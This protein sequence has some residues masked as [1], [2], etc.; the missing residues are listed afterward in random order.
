MAEV[1]TTYF[2]A[3]KTLENSYRWIFPALI[4]KLWT[5]ISQNSHTGQPISIS[6]F[7]GNTCFSISSFFFSPNPC[8]PAVLWAQASLP[9]VYFDE[10]IQLQTSFPLSLYALLLFPFMPRLLRVT[11][12]M[13]HSVICLYLCFP[14]M[15]GEISTWTYRQAPKPAWLHGTLKT[16]RQSD[17]SARITRE[18][19]LAFG[20]STEGALRCAAVTNLALYTAMPLLRSTW[21]SV[22]HPDFAFGLHEVV[23]TQ[24]AASRR[25]LLSSH[26]KCLLQ[27]SVAACTK[28]TSD[29]KW[30]TQTRAGPELC[31]ASSDLPGQSLPTE[32]PLL[33]APV[34]CKCSPCTV[35][36]LHPCSALLMP[37]YLKVRP[38]NSTLVNACAKL[39]WS[40][41]QIRMKSNTF[42]FQQ[43]P[44]C[45][46]CTHNQSRALWC[47][48]QPSHTLSIDTK[49][50]I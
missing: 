27:L 28:S 5:S 2:W 4:E 20:T 38:S 23:I 13:R 49:V 47:K 10:D 26:P 15:P 18:N 31:L 3:G 7:R 25:N 11:S 34:L 35:F 44:M 14:R 12:E 39:Q 48:K 40:D 8:H 22:S 19:S 9:E 1:S 42:P 17:T 36:A 33:P 29:G 50:F 46:A 32:G 43:A 16:G 37:C 30:H 45:Q 41:R 24:L 6:I 21:H